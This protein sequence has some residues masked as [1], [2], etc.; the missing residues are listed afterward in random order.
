MAKVWEQVLAN[1]EINKRRASLD[2]NISFFGSSGPITNST[3]T[4]ASQSSTIELFGVE[5]CMFASNFPVDGLC[6]SYQ[7]I[8]NGFDTIVADFSDAARRA[9]FHDNAIRIY[10]MP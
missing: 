10:R 4:T 9:L 3:A 7:T 8:F 5:R 6:A 1:N 2:K